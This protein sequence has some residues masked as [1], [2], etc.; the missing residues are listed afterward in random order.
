MLKFEQSR[1]ALVVLGLMFGGCA[2]TTNIPNAGGVPPTQVDP[3]VAG[4]VSGVGIES[5]DI[6]AMTDE[7]MRDMLANPTLAGRAK[8]PRVV[9][10]S[11]YFKNAGSQAINRD[12][13]TSRLRV[14]LNRASQGRMSFVTRTNLTM[15][16]SERD[17]KRD[18][19]T[20]EG[21]TGKTAAMA[22]ADF[23]LQGEIA[24]LDSRNVR[25][26]LLQRYNQ[27]TFE[28]LDLETGEIVW[29]GQYEVER[30]AADDVVYR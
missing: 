30:A 13:I 20:D 14:N 7:M 29:S 25:T 1:V 16:Q 22:G 11:G 26:G 2:T 9:I 8:A 19:T 17:M 15:V 10:D 23:R 18:G 5:H 4:P 6:V 24:S 21:T 3:S 28:M 27:I 12:L